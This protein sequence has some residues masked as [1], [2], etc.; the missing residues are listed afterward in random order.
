MKQLFFLVMAVFLAVTTFLPPTQAQAPKDEGFRLIEP[1]RETEPMDLAKARSFLQE[2]Y[3][4]NWGVGLLGF[5]QIKDN[6]G[7]TGKGVFVCVCDTGEPTHKDLEASKVKAANHT[8]DSF[9]D[10]RNGHATHVGGIINEI[11]PNAGILYSKSLTASGGGSEFT[12]AKGIRWC[13]D[14]GAHIINLSL[15]GSQKAPYI[16]EAI[17]EAIA[18]GIIVIAAAGNNGQSSTR[19]TMGYP[20]RYQE[21]VAVGSINELLVVSD[22]SSS[23][24][25]GDIVAPGEMVLSTW[26]DQQYIVLSGTSMAAPFMAGLAALYLEAG[27]LGEALE[28]TLEATATDVPPVSFDRYSFYG[29]V[30]TRLYQAI[31]STSPPDPPIVNPPDVPKDGDKK[32]FQWWPTGVLIGVFFLGLA[33]ILILVKNQKG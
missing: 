6:L 15:G 21:T 23:G 8:G 16:K 2:Q 31:D 30:S 11:A 5:D 3:Y 1:I 19:N 32:G 22:F 20:A 18:E 13:K 26:L 24:E 25:E 17:D 12:V 4:R 29:I 14:Q 7:L 9:V 28:Q 33:I 27:L 10:D